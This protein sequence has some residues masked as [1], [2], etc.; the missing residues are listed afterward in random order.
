MPRLGYAALIV[1]SA[2]WACIGW[3][4]T[5]ATSFQCPGG[6]WV[7]N[8]GTPD[9][10]TQVESA[11]AGDLLTD[12]TT[13]VQSDLH[14]TGGTG[15]WCI[16][17][18]ANA[19]PDWDQLVAGNDGTDTA[20][21]D[22]GNGTASSAT[23]SGSATGLTAAT[24]YKTAQGVLRN[25][26]RSK[27]SVSD[28]FTTLGGAA[29][30]GDDL[31]NT[32]FFYSPTGND[33]NNGLSPATAKLT[34]PSSLSTGTNVYLETDG[35]W[36]QQWNISWNG[37]AGDLV[38]I[39][40]YCIDTSDGNK[41]KA[42]TSGG[43]GCGEK[44]EVRGSLT[45]ECAEG[46]WTCDVGTY[47]GAQAGFNPVPSG[48]FAGL[49]DLGENR[50]YVHLRNI[51]INNS[52]ARGLD[53][54]TAQHVIIDGV[55]IG[56]TAF[57]S[58]VAETNSKY[59]VAIGNLADRGANCEE[60]ED[61]GRLPGDFVAQS[62]CGTSGQPAC[63]GVGITSLNSYS[64]I[65]GNVVT[66]CG[67]E[68]FNSSRGSHFW[69]EH[70]IAWETGVSF[71]ANHV[72]HG[73]YVRN[74]AAGDGNDGWVNQSGFVAAMEG[75]GGD[76]GN[77][78][79]AHNIAVGTATGVGLRNLNPI[80]E[81]A[82]YTQWGL[83]Y[84]N[85]ALYTLSNAMSIAGSGAALAGEENE[86]KN[87]IAAVTHSEICRAQ[88]TAGTWAANHWNQTLVGTEQTR[89]S[90]TGDIV[91][92]LTWPHSSTAYQA[93]TKAQA[94]T[95]WSLSDYQPTGGAPGPGTTVSLPAWVTTLTNSSEWDFAKG[96]DGSGYHMWGTAG[97]T[98]NIAA[99]SILTGADCLGLGSP[100]D[101]G[102][103]Q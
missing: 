45:D 61:E 73:I 65:A 38:E 102:A 9:C 10:P 98:V 70:N 2:F 67:G 66:N 1:F 97:C 86:F 52:A 92:T 32:G 30:G 88:T 56:R 69:Y 72:H 55:D 13:N 71:Y 82:G 99:A 53:M 87:N 46:T 58:L 68:A 93:I 77:N 54:R 79:Y 101:M 29:P 75:N 8:P 36:N 18:A 48:I 60:A 103:M 47:N 64:L 25:G 83:F 39:D 96:Y 17:P 43:T 59:I 33:S 4:A 63:I 24:D 81:A 80:A 91:S 44:A 62:N 90:G 35:V 7:V 74:L 50:Q 51:Q 6:E 34:L 26:K 37:T 21:V 19:D 40:T 28:T 27:V 89:C 41:P 20:C 22:S 23:F 11:R 42:W 3:A 16:Y 57:N 15:Y 95:D 12:T 49:V 85:T 31:T 78:V 94:L 14:Q 100:P 5:E 76:A 84:F